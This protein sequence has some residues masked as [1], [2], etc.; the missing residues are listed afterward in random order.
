MAFREPQRGD[1]IVFRYP[2]DRRLDFIKRCI[3]VGGDE[4]EIVYQEKSKRGNLQPQRNKASLQEIVDHIEEE[5]GYVIRGIKHTHADPR[6]LLLQAIT[7]L[8]GTVKMIHEST[9]LLIEWEH[10]KSALEK[11]KDQGVESISFEKQVDTITER[12]IIAVKESNT[13]ELCKEAGLPE[14]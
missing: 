4:V 9:R 2:R 13:E 10:K 12:V 7:K 1:V 3:A 8:E 11:A 6:T 14:L 5:T